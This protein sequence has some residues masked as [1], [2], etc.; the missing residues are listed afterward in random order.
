MPKQLP[1]VIAA[2]KQAFVAAWF[3]P[4]RFPG[5]E[6][7]K[8]GGYRGKP[9]SLH[10]GDSRPCWA[11]SSPACSSSPP[12]KRGS[13]TFPHALSLTISVKKRR[14]LLKTAVRHATVASAAHVPQELCQ[15]LRRP[16]VRH[17]DRSD[18]TDVGIADGQAVVTILNDDGGRGKTWVGPH[19]RRELVDGGPLES[20]RSP[21]RQ[22]PGTH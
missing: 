16:L 7:A 13:S 17:S 12:F 21:R 19:E 18:P 8:A 2:R 22:Q 15:H 3:G 11:S 14:A 10:P 1:E 4:D 6:A 9:A 5:A 20:H